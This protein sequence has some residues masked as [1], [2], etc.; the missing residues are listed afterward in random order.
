MIYGAKFVLTACHPHSVYNLYTLIDV[1]TT[2]SV[3]QLTCSRAFLFFS[4][5]VFSRCSIVISLW[6]TIIGF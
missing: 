1:S 5:Y 2:L 6:V 4:F 3:I